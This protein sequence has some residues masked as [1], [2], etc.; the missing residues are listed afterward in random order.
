MC[1]ESG[2]SAVHQTFSSRPPGRLVD[3][4]ATCGIYQMVSGPAEQWRPRQ[5]RL[6]PIGRDVRC[7]YCLGPTESS[8]RGPVEPLEG[9]ANWWRV[10]P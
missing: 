9:E 5:E 1:G 10:Q 6:H 7:S 8:E 2:V 3:R 4:Q